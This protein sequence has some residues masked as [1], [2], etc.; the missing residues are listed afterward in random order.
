MAKMKTERA[1][2]IIRL[3]G[4]EVRAS[5]NPK[6][7]LALLKRL[8]EELRTG[9]AQPSKIDNTQHKS[10]L[11]WLLKKLGLVRECCS[12][13]FC[14]TKEEEIIMANWKHHVKLRQLFTED[15]DHASIQASMTAM[16]DVIDAAP[17][18]T[19]FS[20]ANFR[21]IPEGDEVIGPVDYANKL[22]D[23]IYDFADDHLIWIE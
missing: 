14:R 2:K 3:P 18:F 22:L 10:F 7:D 4:R 6:E 8:T 5:T 21:S 20:T 12:R 1:V 13:T 15:E 17:C 23:R 16:A 11:T 19:G 9:E